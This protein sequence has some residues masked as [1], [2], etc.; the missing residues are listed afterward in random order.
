MENMKCVCF[1]GHRKLSNVTAIREATERELIRLI[2]EGATTFLN[3]AALGYDQ[4]TALLILE[5][6]NKYPQ[7]KLCMVLPCS[8][9]AQVKK[10][11]EKDKS[12]YYD[13]LSKADEVIT[14][15]NVYYNGCM[16]ARNRYLIKNSGY[17][18]CFLTQ[19]TGGTVYTVKK[20]KENGLK[21]I[22]I[23][24]RLLILR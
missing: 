16:Q 5:L 4:L 18:I 1:T 14:L 12:V 24:E 22:N 6:K 10:W 19:T 11:C 8:P 9:E 20:A 7:I 15:S 17:C 2:E 3:G 13:I 23:A 21:V